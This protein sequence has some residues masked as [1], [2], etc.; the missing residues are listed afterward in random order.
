MKPKNDRMRI[1]LRIPLFILTLGLS[2]P[3][4]K[5]IH[6][7]APES[8]LKQLAYPLLVILLIYLFEKTRLSDKVVHVAFGIAIVIC[9]LGI[10]MLTEPEDYWWLQNYIS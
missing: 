6:I 4:S 8:W 7:L 10:E 3:V 9:G 5:L 1:K 2:I